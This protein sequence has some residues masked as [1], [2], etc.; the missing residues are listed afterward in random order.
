V[1]NP[2]GTSPALMIQ[3]RRHSSSSKDVVSDLNRWPAWDQR[4]T[5]TLHSPPIKYL[6][7]EEYL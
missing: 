1:K 5:F 7:S 6:P 3:H 4:I 2:T